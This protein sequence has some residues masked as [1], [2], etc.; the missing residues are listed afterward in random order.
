MLFMTIPLEISGIE[1]NTFSL[2]GMSTKTKVMF[3][4]YRKDSK[5]FVLYQSIDQG[6]A[7]VSER[8]VDNVTCAQILKIHALQGLL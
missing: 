3:S 7:M 2:V 8:D 4:P 6:I 1:T 5:K